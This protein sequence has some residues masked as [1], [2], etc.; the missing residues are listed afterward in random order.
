MLLKGTLQESGVLLSLVCK[1]IGH[2]VGRRRVWNDGIDFRTTCRRCQQDLI[3]PESG[4]RVYDPERD[5]NPE[6]SAHPRTADAPPL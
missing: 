5:A 3:R 1:I 6:R 4:W 2:R